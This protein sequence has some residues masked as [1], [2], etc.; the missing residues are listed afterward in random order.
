MGRERAAVLGLA[1]E[2]RR[3]HGGRGAARKD[4]GV[5]SPGRGAFDA[6][7]H[8]ADEEDIRNVDFLRIDAV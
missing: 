1:G 4:H 5:G 2:F 3:V 7:F 8:D 6:R